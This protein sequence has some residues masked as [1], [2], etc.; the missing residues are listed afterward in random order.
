M[1]ATNWSSANT[2]GTGR[3]IGGRRTD[4]CFSIFQRGKNHEWTNDSTYPAAANRCGCRGGRGQGCFSGPRTTCVG[5][6]QFQVG[7]SS[8]RLGR[9]R[10]ERR[11]WQRR[12]KLLWPSPMSMTP[13]WP[14]L[15]RGSCRLVPGRRHFSTTDACSMPCTRTSTPCSSPRPTTT[16]HRPRWRPCNSASTSSARN[17]CATNSSSA[18]AGRCGPAIQGRHANGQPRPLWRGVPPALRVPLGRG[19]RRSPGSAQLER[20]RQWRRRRPAAR[21]PCASGPALGRVAGTGALRDYHPGLHPLYWRYYWDFGTGALGDWGCHNLDG[22]FWALRLGHPTSVECL[23]KTGGSD[24]KYPQGSI[25]R[26]EVPARGK[27]PALKVYWYD[28]IRTNTDPSVKG[29]HGK[30]LET[31]PNPPPL[32]AA[33]QKKYNRQFDR[34]F[35]G[36]GTFYVG[37]KGIMNTGNYGNGPRIVPEEAHQAFPPPERS[38][39]RIK[40]PISPISSSAVRRESPPWPT[41]STGRLSPSSC[42]WGTWPFSR[43]WATK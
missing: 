11:S 20:V 15:P 27:M 4:C 24:E 43:A 5:L 26:W 42:S 3:A 16:T 17:L 34:S 40:G 13:D 25:I 12:R 31:V 1:S 41:S 29:E 33:L 8:D 19:H 30:M 9:A 23:H 14:W 36:G 38:L 37:T 7:H 10:R 28:G 39:P 35:A 32:E 6:A 21:V 22:V 18:D 2:N